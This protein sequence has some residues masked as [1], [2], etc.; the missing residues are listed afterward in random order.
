M[1]MHVCAAGCVVL[2]CAV[3]EP[4]LRCRLLV[5]VEQAGDGA[6]I[7]YSP[8]SGGKK[9]ELHTLQ[10]GSKP[11][12]MAINE[13]TNIL[14]WVDLGLMEISYAEWNM[15][16]L[17][18]IPLVALSPDQFVNDMTLL[19]GYLYLTDRDGAR[20]QRIF[21]GEGTPEFEDVFRGLHAPMSVVAEWEERKHLHSG[22][23]GCAL[24]LLCA[25]LRVWLCSRF[26]PV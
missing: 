5:W 25:P 19:D 23:Y 24:V 17:E 7:F 20:I 10:S 11:V 9:Q 22:K 13:T 26:Q 8:F 15:S 1:S 16:I 6:A 18:P 12:A 4:H 3:S 14:Y 2:C 21:H